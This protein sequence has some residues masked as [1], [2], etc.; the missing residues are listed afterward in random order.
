MIKKPSQQELRI[1]IISSEQAQKHKMILIKVLVPVLSS[2]SVVSV[3]AEMVFLNKLFLSYNFYYYNCVFSACSQLILSCLS[4]FRD[5]FCLKF[6]FPTTFIIVILCFE[7]VLSLFSVVSVFAEMIF[8]LVFSFPT[9]FI[10]N[11]LHL[12]RK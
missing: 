5:V 10:K 4:F 1:L 11:A 12:E 8:K 3:F 9:T 6:S 7:P 2:F